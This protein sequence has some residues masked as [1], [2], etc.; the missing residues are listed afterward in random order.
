MKTD[1]KSK[2]M[3]VMKGT[4][5][6]GIVC[7]DGVIIGA[8][9]RATMGTFIASKETR[10]VFK[11]DETL[12]MTVAGSVGDAQEL[13]RLL[14]ANNEIYKMSENKPFSPKSA[15][16]LLSIM[17]QQN[18]MMPYYVQLI[19]GGIDMEGE[20]GLYSLDPLG[21]YSEE[22]MY[23]AT[24]SGTELALGYLEDSY[25]KNITTKEAVRLAARAL[26]IATSR[27]SAVGDGM[28]IAVIN[29]SGYTEYKDKELDKFLPQTSSK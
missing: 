11:I 27:D 5:T 9:R 12:G 8:D 23:T 25:K 15:T 28:I 10:K 4:T 26:S 14:K 16:T 13:V 17:L 24:G 2:L 22:S 7:S 21:G 19:I 18:K 3:E 1:M 20:P 6:V 29:K